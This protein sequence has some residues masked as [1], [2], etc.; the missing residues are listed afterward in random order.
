MRLEGVRLEKI[1]LFLVLILVFLGFFRS[2]RIIILYFFFEVRLIPTF[3]VIVFWGRN[4]ERVRAGFYLI[5][6][7]MFISLPL[8]VYIF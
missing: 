6:Y 2:L 8:L 4:P 3:F 7:T 1:F 5:L